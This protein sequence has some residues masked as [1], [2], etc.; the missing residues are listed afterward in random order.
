M[1][2]AITYGAVAEM[3]GTGHIPD[4]LTPTDPIPTITSTGGRQGDVC[5]LPYLVAKIRPISG[6]PRPCTAPGID[7]TAGAAGRNRHVLIGD[8]DWVE[9][10]VVDRDRDFGM[11]IVPQGGRAFLF[12]SGEHG[13]WAIPPGVW[14][15]FGRRDHRTAVDA[16]ASLWGIT[17]DQWAAGV[18]T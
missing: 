13:A 14:R 3:T 18:T 5:V 16:Q 9:G 8:G 12:H 6:E 10:T 1:N 17:P 2:T 7:I 11:L 4:H 15:V